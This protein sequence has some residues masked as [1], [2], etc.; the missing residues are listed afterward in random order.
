MLLNAD[1]KNVCVLTSKWKI[2]SISGLIFTMI[3]IA[4]ISIGY[5][6]LKY[7][8]IKWES[9]FNSISTRTPAEYKAYK[10]KS[11][12]LYGC[13]AFY[14]LMIML[15]F[16]TYNIWLMGAVAIG[17][18]LGHYFFSFNGPLGASLTSSVGCH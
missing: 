3:A 15:I 11:S 1:Y 12:M 13:A 17:S 6:L 8:T 2:K 7:W 9:R 16:M 18:I 10:L 4:T 5:E 14:S